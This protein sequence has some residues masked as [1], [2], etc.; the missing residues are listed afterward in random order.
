MTDDAT[1]P[2]RVPVLL[3]QKLPGPLDYRVPDGLALA[4]G[5]LV[6]V[7]LGR[8]HVLGVVWDGAP[9]PALPPSRLRPVAAHLPGPALRAPLRRFIDWVAQYTL[10]SPGEVLAMA[11]RAYAPPPPAPAP[12]GL[13]ANPAIGP[14]PRSAARSRVRAAA[15]TPQTLATLA[16]AAGVSASLI[17]AMLA[18]GQLHR[19]PLPEAPRPPPAPLPLSPAQAG[20]AATLPALG[21]FAVTLL[22]GVTGSGKTEVYFHAIRACRAAGR[23]ALVL[24]PE[25]ALAVPWQDRF[26]AAFGAPPHAWHSGLGAKRRRQTWRAVAEGTAGVVVGAR[27]ALFLPFADLGL[28]IVD[29]EHDAAF[30]QEDGVI[31]HA[32]DMAVVRA[33]LESSPILLVSATPSLETL[34]NA[35]S[36]R[37]GHLRL[38]DRA[39]GA[40]LPRIQAIDLRQTPPARG[41]FL[42]PPLT[43]AIAH[44]LA[45]GHQVMLFLNRRGYA[46]LTLCRQCGQRCQCPNCTA[47]LVA[48]RARRVLTCHHCGHTIP[49]PPACPACAAVDSLVPVGPGVERIDEEAA[50]LFPTA[51]RL[52]LT[53]DTIAGP[54]AAARAADAILTREI[55]IIVGTQII[56]K[57]WHFPHLTLVG[58]VDAD[59]GLG[60]GDL[61]AG[62]RMLQLLHQVAGRAGRAEIPGHVLLQ[63]HTPHHPVMQAL[64]AADPELFLAE[65]RRLRARDHWPPF[66]RLA[67]LIIAAPEEALAETAARALGRAAPAGPGVAVFGPAP[68]PLAMLRGQH[69]RRLLL[70]TRRDIAPQPLLR[71]WLAAVSLPA[72][73]RVT[74]DVDPMSFL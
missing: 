31:Y 45:Q 52:T 70:R 14:A 47:W 12:C 33:R 1:P 9:D 41:R 72:K 37:Y 60:G 53:S 62:E 3:A 6:S 74:V 32:R 8:R 44:T 23:Q 69:R 51:R 57:G 50:T 35:Q 19:V 28:I 5:D 73:V 63:T 7:P 58:V 38:P 18:A 40:T 66:G 61:R 64:L 34:V 29:E 67:A 68:A 46:P 42:A 55:D 13:Q 11:L 21:R 4:P 22:E 36:G 48:H 43:E 39:G 27:S 49:L 71:Q 20:L 54:E 15:A 59:L 26:T 24:L 25:I 65:E 2:V 56:A 16:Q 30:K 10:T 17:R